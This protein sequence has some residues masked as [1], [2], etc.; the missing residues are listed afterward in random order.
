[1]RIWTIA[2]IDMMRKPD[3]NMSGLRSMR[4][5]TTAA[6][7]C[8]V[9][10][11]VHFSPRQAQGQPK[12]APVRL[13]RRAVTR[14]IASG[15]KFLNASR[16]ET[17]RCSGSYDR[18]FPG[19]VDSLVIAT[20]I[21]LDSK[22]DSEKL[23]KAV[24]SAVEQ[25]P[26]TVYAR[27]MRLMAF[28]RLGA[29][30]YGTLLAEDAE[31][32]QER[33]STN[34]GWG[35]GVGHPTTQRRPKWTDMCNTTFAV[36]A[37]A[38]A[39][40]AGVKVKPEVWKKAAVYLAK[41]QNPDGG[42]GYE[43]AGGSGLRLRGNS[44][45][46]MTASGVTALTA[47]MA[48]LPLDDEARADYAASIAKGR[49]WLGE[50]YDIAKIPKWGWGEV[51]YWP[52]FYVYMLSRVAVESGSSQI[53][54]HSWQD[55]LLGSL[56]SRQRP[57]GAWR[58]NSK[59]S[60][61]DII[62]TC[63][64]LMAMANAQKPVLINKLLVAGQKPDGSDVSALASWLGK[65]AR[66]DAR[67][68]FIPETVSQSVLDSAPVLYITAASEMLISE[69]CVAKI[70]A[71]VSR[72]GM[73]IVATPEGD[74]GKTQESFMSL[75]ANSYYHATKLPATHPAFALRYK[76]TAPSPLSVTSIGDT[77]RSRVFLVS[78]GFA[79]SLQTGSKTAFELTAN[80]A[81]YS[82]IGFAVGAPRRPARAVRVIP[83]AK[84]R[85]IPVARLKYDGDWR[86]GAGGMRYVHNVLASALSLG[87]D[88]RMVD[89]TLPGFDPTHKLLW[90]TGTKT[91]KFTSAQLKSLG[92]YLKKGGMIFVDS[93]MGRPEFA[94]QTAKMIG[95]SLGV[96]TPSKV[97]LTDPLITGK[98]GG[99][100]GCD[101]TKASVQNGDKK[102]P[103]ADMLT[104]IRYKGR[105]VA[106][107]SQCGITLTLDGGYAHGCVA[108]SPNDAR[109]LA[110]NIILMAVTR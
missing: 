71:Y 28:S 86:I 40:M 46:S 80:L 48:K 53:G 22:G 55:D 4:T 17:G 14:S 57:D 37:L 25:K 19:G 85:M 89:I 110:A 47:V 102:T 74:T 79:Q 1:M 91:P 3:T 8:V 106:V 99:G 24:K 32:L 65:S 87:V 69:L 13:S 20:G 88:S 33:Q 75:F 63:F 2:S 44:F 27:A 77:C 29:E 58:V 84:G 109:G 56:V 73:V 39:E 43:P 95:A 31:F 52:Y 23:F 10:F 62:H 54:G 49:K 105:V 41:V 9:G 78:G 81:A 66:R 26:T 60:P 30:K 59:E 35:Y 11:S 5:I 12:K 18:R 96:L 72:G 64:A 38:D 61:N 67:W 76:I 97:T 50:N 16:D 98:F 6:L 104:V 92:D 93:A 83:V 107:I 36:L 94:Q 21:A 82:G 15:L 70:R 100:M 51:S 45:G 108:P 101:L 7:L 90:M 103:L 68:Q 34:G 42:W